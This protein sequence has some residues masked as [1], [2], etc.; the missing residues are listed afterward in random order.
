[1]LQR[2]SAE[3]AREMFQRGSL[4][5]LGCIINHQPY[6]VPINYILE[7]DRAFVH[8]L[9]GAKIN[10]MRANPHVCLQTDEILN[11]IEWK[12]V[13][14]FGEY[15][16][17]SNEEERNRVLAKLLRTFPKLTPVESA[18]AFD[19]GAPPIVVFC[20]NIKRYTAV[21]EG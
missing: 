11:D 4:A 5:R 17:I 16:E 15:E 2:L 1:M 9:P 3:E 10:A 19:G 18:I 7:G 6:V 8:S 14:A 20:I 21:A 13:L 12:S